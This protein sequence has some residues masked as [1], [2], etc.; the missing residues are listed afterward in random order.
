MAKLFCLD[1]ADLE[2][3]LKFLHPERHHLLA[4]GNAT[5]DER[6]VFVER[7]NGHWPQRQL[8]ARIDNVNRGARSAADMGSLATVASPTGLSVTVG[9]IPSA[10]LSSEWRMVK[11]AA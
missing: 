5:G 1:A 11:R 9:V 8:A 4:G 7:G 2:P 6:I 10:T 3:G